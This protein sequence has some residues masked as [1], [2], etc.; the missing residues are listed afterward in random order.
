MF[1]RYDGFGSLIDEQNWDRRSFAIGYLGTLRVV[2]IYFKREV[3]VIVP[4][5]AEE[6]TEVEYDKKQVY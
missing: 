3:E 6:I 4:L 5:S 1:L 2:R